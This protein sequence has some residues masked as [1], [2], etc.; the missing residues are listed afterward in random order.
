MRPSVVPSLEATSIPD[1][2]GLEQLSFSTG[3][4]HSSAGTNDVRVGIDPTAAVAVVQLSRPAKR[5]ALTQAM[6]DR[7]VTLLGQLDRNEAV[8]AVVLMGTRKGAFSAGVDIREL[9]Q[10]TTG[11]AHERKFLSDLNGAFERFSKPIIAAVEG[12]ALGGGFE[13][14]LSCDIIYAGQE[15][16]FGL[17]EVSIGTI[18]GAGGTQRLVRALGQYK[19][20]ELILSRQLISGEELAQRGLVNRV[21]KPDEDVVLEAKK[22]ADR[23]A[24]YSRPVVRMAKQA[25]LAAENNH[26][27][28]GMAIEKQLYYM[29]FSLDDFK[30][31]T[32]AFLT[33]Q[34][35]EF[36]HH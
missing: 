13:V 23:I 28:A 26:L 25:V 35:P 36:M 3:Q 21:F 11:E 31:G 20:M 18:P 24:A 16:T 14:A 15:A 7:L 32:N 6:I 5:N 33:K 30:T 2:E 1:F 17:P 19:A 12:L 27:Y 8:R 29:T 9:T 34:Q 10:L 22:L 4:E